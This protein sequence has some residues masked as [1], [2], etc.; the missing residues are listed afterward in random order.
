MTEVDG[1]YQHNFIESTN[2]KEK[3]LC[4]I[5]KKHKK[6]HL[7]YIPDSNNEDENENID[8]HQDII[9]KDDN[10]IKVNKDEIRM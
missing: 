3:L 1:I 6:Y 7:D 5:C 10:L 9:I 2:P 8:N 4:F